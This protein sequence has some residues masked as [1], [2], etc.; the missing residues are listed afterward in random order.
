M[1]MTWA[2]LLGL[3]RHIVVENKAFR[4]NESWQ[5]TVG[6]TLYVKRLGVNWIR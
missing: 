6:V 2:L 5:S 4:A 3:V 1:E